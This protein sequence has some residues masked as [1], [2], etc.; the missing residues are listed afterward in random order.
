MRCRPHVL[1]G[2][3]VV[4]LKELRVILCVVDHEAGI[5]VR[6]DER[7]RCVSQLVR[8]RLESRPLVRRLGVSRVPFGWTGTAADAAAPSAAA[9]SARSLAAPRLGRLEI[10][11]RGI[12]ADAPVE[13]PRAGEVRARL[14]SRKR[15]GAASAPA[16]D[17]ATP[18]AIERATTEQA[19]YFMVPRYEARESPVSA[20]PRSEGFPYELPHGKPQLVASVQRQPPRPPRPPR[21]SLCFGS[22]HSVCSVVIGELTLSGL[23]EDRAGP[24]G[25]QLVQEPH[26]VVAGELDEH[27]RDLRV[28]VV[29]ELRSSRFIAATRRCSWPFNSVFETTPSASALV[30]DSSFCSCS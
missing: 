3:A 22:V 18:A 14:M 19:A 30:N 25:L 24:P 21:K 10:R 26:H 5:V 16:T 12:V 15:L 6:D 27:G 7:V 4:G 11:L 20:G 1:I 28:Q 2:G 9:K 29:A 13:C 17:A 23:P 8:Q